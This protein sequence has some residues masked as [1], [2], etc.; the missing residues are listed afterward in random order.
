MVLVIPNNDVIS[1]KFS[2]F[3]DIVTE[4]NQSRRGVRDLITDLS[5]EKIEAESNGEVEERDWT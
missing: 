2:V 3:N 1:Q 5:L 4:I